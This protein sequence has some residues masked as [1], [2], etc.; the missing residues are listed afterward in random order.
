MITTLVGCSYNI[1]YSYLDYVKLRRAK[2]PGFSGKI[3]S[4]EEQAEFTA[5]YEKVEKN[6]AERLLRSNLDFLSNFP[7]TALLNLGI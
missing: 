4:Q 2:D 5:I 7:Q 1:G 6:A 3:Q